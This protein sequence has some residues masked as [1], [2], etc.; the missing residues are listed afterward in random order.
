MKFAVTLCV[1][2]FVALAAAKPQRYDCN[3]TI[4]GFGRCIQDCPR[5]T[6]RYATAC[7]PFTPEATCNRPHP[8]A[9]DAFICDFSACYCSS[10]KVRNVITG[11]CVALED[12][13]TN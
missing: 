1:L 10:P 6:Y 4:D 13:P 9:E 5:G 12:C 11:K 8:R 3:G 7:G 2:V